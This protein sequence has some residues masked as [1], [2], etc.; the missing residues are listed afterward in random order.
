[1]NGERLPIVRAEGCSGEPSAGFGTKFRGHQRFRGHHAD[2][3][4]VRMRRPLARF[5][6]IDP[7]RRTAASQA[8]SNS[9]GMTPHGSRKAR[10]Y[11]DVMRPLPIPCPPTLV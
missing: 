5:G 11:V 6:L 2:L 1:M 10:L 7:T 8:D 3:A 4:R 9:A